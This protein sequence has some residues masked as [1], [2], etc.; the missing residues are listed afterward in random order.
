[1]PGAPSSR[2]KSSKLSSAH[3]VISS[4][5]ALAGVAIAGWQ[6]LGPANAPAPA[7]VNV[8]VTVDPAAT[9]PPPSAEPPAAPKGDAE[10]GAA[11]AGEV[12][13]SAAL[14][15]G[16][17]QRYHFADLFDGRPETALALAAP[18]REI[19]VMVTFPA[20]ST[21]TITGFEY[22]PPANADPA[23]LATTADV[24]VLPEGQIGAA[25]R[26]VASF[27]LPTTAG[28]QSFALPA[29]E[30]GKGLWLRVAGGS[31]V[32]DFRIVRTP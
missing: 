26:P 28:R 3:I 2:D 22:E 17:D 15:D 11:L 20:G 31:L 4:F 5:A 23:S 10:A 24:M 16:S 25:G 13:Y 12:T 9:T 14:N 27:T 21:P 1:M 6:A 30:S 32:G 8:T 7:P 19:N 29:P 18:D